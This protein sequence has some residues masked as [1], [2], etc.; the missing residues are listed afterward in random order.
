M[1]QPHSHRRARTAAAVAAGAMLLCALPMTASAAGGLE[2]STAYPGIT[3]QAGDDLSF[4][5]DFDNDLGSGQS[6]ALSVT[7]LP[8]GLEGVFTGNG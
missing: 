8:E 7:S 4:T 2:M 1:Y 3:A 6:V 5:M